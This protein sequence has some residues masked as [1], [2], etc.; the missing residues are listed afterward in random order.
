MYCA[1]ERALTRVEQPDAMGNPLGA[2][3]SDR[4]YVGETVEVEIRGLQHGNEFLS[5]VVNHAFSGGLI[6]TDVIPPVRK[7]IAGK[8]LYFSSGLVP[9]DRGSHAPRG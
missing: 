9:H 6:H 1:Q 7:K 5:V 2:T 3:I 8:R 4:E